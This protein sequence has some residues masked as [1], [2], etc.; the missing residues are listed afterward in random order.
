MQL[1]TYIWVGFCRAVILAVRLGQ[2]G[3]K[4]QLGQSGQ[5]GQTSQRRLTGHTDL[6]F[7]LDFS[8]NS[9]RAAFAI[10]AMVSFIAL[11]AGAVV[12]TTV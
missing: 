10:L 7:K 2:T 3:Q 8:G 11:Q 6:R 4:G 1:Y 9:C 5:T 12:V